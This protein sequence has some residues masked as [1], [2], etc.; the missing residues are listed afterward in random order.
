MPGKVILHGE[1]AVVYGKAAV[2]VSVGLRT[3]VTLTAQ[4]S[5]VVLELPDLNWTA[6]WECQE[7]LPLTAAD[8]GREG[9][10][11]IL[12]DVLVPHLSALFKLD[13]GC[14]PEKQAAL[15]FLFLYAGIS[16]RHGSGEFPCVRVTVQSQLPVGAGLGSSAALSVGISGALLALLGLSHNRYLI[17]AWAF[18][19]ERILHGKPS[20]IDNSI[21]TYGGAL[22]FRDGKVLHQLESVPSSYR[23]VLVDT[24][25]ARN[26]HSLVALVRQRYDR[27]PEIVGPI[28]D[29]IHGISERSWQLLQEQ[30]E[31][32]KRFDKASE[33]VRLNATLLEALGVG[34]PRLEEVGR[35]AAGHGLAAKLTGAGG[36][37]CALILLPPEGPSEGIERCLHEAGFACWEASLG[38]PG[39][40]VDPCKQ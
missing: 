21:C 26:T 28:L 23:V 4:E 31:P 30:G 9:E 34:H 6:K 15:A 17:S 2:A 16:L 22:L 13:A 37:G 14:G 36:G 38:C 29:A 27:L 3:E 24:R 10:A 32:S 20:G 12:S 1:H 25:V 11:A 5:G 40:T 19:A 8:T 35:L 33:L 39:V 7:F 18:Q